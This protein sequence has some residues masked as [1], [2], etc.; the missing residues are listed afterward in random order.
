M[1]TYSP[2]RTALAG[3]AVAASGVALAAP[4]TYE[5][6]PTHTYP[7]FEADHLGGL[8]VWRGKFNKT[9]GQVVMDREAGT[10]AIDLVVEIDSIDFGLEQMNAA[11]R[12]QSLFDAERF[13]QAR[14]RGQLAGFTD[15]RPTRVDGELTLKGITR[16]LTL[17]IRRFKCMP[18]PLF[19]RELCGAD[20]HAE[21]Q[22]D[23]FGIDAGKAYGFDM[24]VQLRVQVEA[25]AT[26]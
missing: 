15:G 16:P 18:H 8:S 2:V 24:A 26:R 17:E 12:G 3:L 4:V 6:D 21:F 22:R 13:P 19:K 10:G 25:L 23:A 20:A 9:A 1:T 7:S 14:Y 5:L 11:A